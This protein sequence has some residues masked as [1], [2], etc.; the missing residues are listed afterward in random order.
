MELWLGYVG[1]VGMKNVA[2]VCLLAVTLCS[3]GCFLFAPP[4]PPVMYGVGTGIN[5]NSSNLYRINNFSTAP[6]AVNI[7]ESGAVLTDVAVHPTTGVIFASD[8]LQL[9]TLNPTT[10]ARTLIG[11]HLTLDVITA[12]EFNAQG[13]LFGWGALQ[14]RCFRST[15]RPVRQQTS[16]RPMPRGP[17]LPGT[18]RLTSM[19]RS[20]EGQPRWSAAHRA[21]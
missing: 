17:S 3:S 9:F 4:A 20:S 8:G 14:A 10:G 15:R 13:Q 16:D 11:L 21:S 18:W 1:V 19:V 7:G 12:L 5:D 2:I 6:A